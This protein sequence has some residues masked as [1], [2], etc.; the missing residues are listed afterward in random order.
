MGDVEVEMRKVEEEHDVLEP[1][2]RIVDEQQVGISTAPSMH[3]HRL[4]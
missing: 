1:L 2:N 3:Y 4:Y